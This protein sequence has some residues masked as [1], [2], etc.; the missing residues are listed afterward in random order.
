MVE[1]QKDG[2]E[3][4][5]SKLQFSPQSLFQTSTSLLKTPNSTFSSS[6]LSR[7][8]TETNKHD[9]YYLLASCSHPPPT[10]YPHTFLIWFKPAMDL[11]GHLVHLSLD[12][13]FS[14]WCLDQ[15]HHLGSC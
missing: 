4:R 10:Y 6:R 7:K 1:R 13:K 15:Y 11:P 9:F 14:V 8:S 3:E 5:D 2:N 12:Q